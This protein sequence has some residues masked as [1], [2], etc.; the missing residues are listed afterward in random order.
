MIAGTIVAI[1][2]LMTPF[3]VSVEKIAAL[4]GISIILLFMIAPLAIIGGMTIAIVGG[5]L[6]DKI[7]Y[8]LKAPADIVDRNDMPFYWH[9][10]KIGTM[11]GVLLA[12][13]MFL[14]VPIAAL[15]GD[16]K[17]DTYYR[18]SSL[19]TI[20]PFF[21]VPLVEV[22]IGAISA[23][24]YSIKTTREATVASGIASSISVLIL[25]MGDMA[26]NILQIYFVP[27]FTPGSDLLSLNAYMFMTRVI[28]CYPFVIV[29]LITFAMASGAVWAERRFKNNVI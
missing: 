2:A 22:F 11:A 5:A 7:A 16:A 28:M 26:N 15:S 10:L 27:Y 1:I 17:I 20:I 3:V 23:K 6:K 19:M 24:H 14:P 13:F 4:P 9:S 21:L 29:A 8:T 18:I 12:I 25:F